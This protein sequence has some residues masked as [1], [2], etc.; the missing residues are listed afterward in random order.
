VR[1]SMEIIFVIAA[2]TGR[3]L[4]LPPREPLYRLAADKA[5]VYRGFAD[6]FPL[7]DSVFSKR[8]KTITMDEFIKREGGHDG[9]LTIPPEMMKNVTSS[10]V[11]CEHRAKS[12]IYCGHIDAYLKAVGYSPETRAQDGCFV[13]DKDLYESGMASTENVRV[14]KELCGVSTT[15]PELVILSL[16]AR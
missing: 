3:T 16:L 1:M 2:A 6:F 7:A 10:A 13:F 8:V 12:K 11:A 4:V 14:I 9:R 5:N 15:H